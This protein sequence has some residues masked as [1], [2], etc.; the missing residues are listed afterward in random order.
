MPRQKEANMQKAPLT[1]RGFLRLGMV[2]AGSVIAAA[3]HKALTGAT[4]AG[5]STPSSSAK[6]SLGGNQDVW[7]WVKQINV[8]VDEGECEAVTVQV[9]EKEFKTQPEGKTFTAEVP[10]S[11]GENQ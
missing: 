1:R 2:T 11:G 6:I 9:D 10:L 7:A 3:C 8:R 4:A 5:T